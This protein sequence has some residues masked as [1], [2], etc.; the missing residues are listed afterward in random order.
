MGRR[1]FL[2]IAVA[3]VTFFIL[4]FESRRDI[5]IKA[6]D[7][8]LLSSW[9]RFLTTCEG[10]KRG[11]ISFLIDVDACSLIESLH[12]LRDASNRKCCDGSSALFAQ[13]VDMSPRYRRKMVIVRVGE[14]SQS[15]KRHVTVVGSGTRGLL[16]PN[17]T[18]W[19]AYCMLR[20][21]V[22]IN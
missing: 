15:W 17:Q 20:F 21:I 11:R 9:G 4:H 8:R 6:I 16:C 18:P 7:V 14:V 13:I 10:E 12:L 5:V 19:C 1:S 2:F 3:N 22:S